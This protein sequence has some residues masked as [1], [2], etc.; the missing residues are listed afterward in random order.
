MDDMQDDDTAGD[1][2]R[3]VGEGEDGSATTLDVLALAAPPQPGHPRGRPA[4]KRLLQGDGA[5]L[6]AF[7]FAPGQSFPDHS[8]AHPITVQCLSGELTF[9]CGGET[10]RLTPGTVV[11]CRERVL[12][13]VDC[14]DDAPDANVLLLT[15]LTGE[16]H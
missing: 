12:H 2:G 15:M 6:I 13:R 7:T 8:V 14:S 11:H 4:V 1:D 16:R 3:T 5:N 9:G 10:I